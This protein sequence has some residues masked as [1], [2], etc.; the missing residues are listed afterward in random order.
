[1]FYSIGLDEKLLTSLFRIH[2]FLCVGGVPVVKV[3][4]VL[5]ATLDQRL[6]GGINQ[7]PNGI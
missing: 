4:P 7:R 5:R 1:M 3:A 6:S 2:F